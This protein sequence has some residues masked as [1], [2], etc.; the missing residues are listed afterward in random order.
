[1]ANLEE[2]ATVSRVP[3]KKSEGSK[4]SDSSKKKDKEDD[5]KKRDTGESKDEA[6]EKKN[7]DT[8]KDTY[9]DEKSEGSSSEKE[10]KNSASENNS[11]DK[12][13]EEDN[14]E[15]D[16]EQKSKSDNKKKR[17]RNLR[18]A[19]MTANAAGQAAKL[20]IQ[21]KILAFMKNMMMFMMQL[22]QNAVAL[23]AAAVQAVV[24]AVVH[25]IAT[26]AA[27]LAISTLVAT[28]GV[29]GA[30]AVVVVAAVVVVSGVVNDQTAQRDSSTV[31]CKVEYRSYDDL[32]SLDN[33]EMDAIAN[34]VYSALS[35]YGLPDVNIAGILGNWAIESG[36]DATSVETI[37]SEKYTIGSRKQDAMDDWD[38]FVKDVVFP[39]YGGKTSINESGYQAIDGY[40][41]PGLG[42]G[43]WTGERARM[44]IVWAQNASTED[45]DRH[46][47]DMEVQLSFMI[48]GDTRKGWLEAWTTEATPELAAKNFKEGWEGNGN[49]TLE[50]RQKQAAYYFMRMGEWEVDADYGQ[51]I[52]ELAGTTSVDGDARAAV[53]NYDKCGVR[54]YENASIAKAAVSFAW[55]NKDMARNNDGTSTYKAVCEAVG[56]APPGPYQECAAVV[57]AAVRW[58]GTDDDYPP[59][60]VDAQEAYLE[61]NT[62]RW[63]EIEWDGT[64]EAVLKPGDIFIIN[65]STDSHTFVYVGETTVN[66]LRDWVGSPMDVVAGSYSATNTN[67]RSAGLED[68]FRVSH[69]A[70]VMPSSEYRV[71]RATGKEFLSRYKNAL[72]SGH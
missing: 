52:L 11:S 2:N 71:F 49:G 17:R 10:K 44:L 53:Q 59:H 8:D 25:A 26:V 70:K 29:I 56:I 48:G 58:S 24:A 27:A 21:A 54:S 63:K 64:S 20:M 32:G 12:S 1:M 13:D 33:E 22:L 4:S 5:K 6:A 19:S 36:I 62:S 28:V 39:A 43:Q 42:L 23:A 55:D 57:A 61:S 15:S 16:G 37:Y 65:T 41:Y 34:K 72:D 14:S 68:H 67:G 46:W 35:V 45:L 40:C 60:S 38:E 9:K 47:Y 7:A 18:K 66:E 3:D 31:D 30:V 51:S 50:D 69:G